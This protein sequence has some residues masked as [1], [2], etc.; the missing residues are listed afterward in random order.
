MASQPWYDIESILSLIKGDIGLL[1][2]TWYI[3]ATRVIIAA[4][5]VMLNVSLQ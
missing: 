3:I 2:L 4:V 1:E 5:K